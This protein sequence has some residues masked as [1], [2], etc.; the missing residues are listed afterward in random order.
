MARK[1]EFE[2]G[3]L[4]KVDGMRPDYMD[5]HTLIR[6]VKELAR[7]R[8]EG[9]EHRTYRVEWAVEVWEV[10]QYEARQN[11]PLLYETLWPTREQA[12]L[13]L[14]RIATKNPHHKRLE[15][16]N[17]PHSYHGCGVV[18]RETLVEETSE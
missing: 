9:W 7:P 8:A 6:L 3:V 11:R 14:D 13:D 18:R 17:A 5:G 4:V 10:D 15:W 2:N 16:K 1:L 12:Q